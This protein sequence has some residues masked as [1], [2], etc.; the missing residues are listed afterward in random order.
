M[1]NW[2]EICKPETNYNPDSSEV[3]LVISKASFAYKS[4]QLTLPWVELMMAMV[5]SQHVGANNSF[6]QTDRFFVPANTSQKELGSTWPQ[7]RT[8]N[9]LNEL[10][11]AFLKQIFVLFTIASTLIKLTECRQ[12]YEANQFWII[13]KIADFAKCILSSYVRVSICI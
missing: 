7:K 11:M 5:S 6:L 13:L 10:M 4:L 9:S 2:I 8:H 12:C 1:W 3:T